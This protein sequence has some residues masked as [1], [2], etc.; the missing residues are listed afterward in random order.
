[1]GAL[2][3][4]KGKASSSGIIGAFDLHFLVEKT[5]LTLTKTVCKDHTNHPCLAFLYR[6]LKFNCVISFYSKALS[7]VSWKFASFGLSSCSR[8]CDLCSF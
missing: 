5:L 2:Q 6:L 7:V 4:K 8:Y 3:Y 1:M